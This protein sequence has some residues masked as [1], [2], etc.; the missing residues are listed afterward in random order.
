MKLLQQIGC[1]WV[2]QCDRVEGYLKPVKHFLGLTVDRTGHLNLAAVYLSQLNDGEVS[3]VLPHLMAMYPNSYVGVETGKTNEWYKADYKEP[4]SDLYFHS[5]YRN[6]R[7]DGAI[8]LVYRTAVEALQS[9]HLT[10]EQLVHCLQTW[11]FI[12]CSIQGQLEIWDELTDPEVFQRIWHETKITFNLVDDDSLEWISPEIIELIA[13]HFKVLPLFSTRVAMCYL[14][15]RYTLLEQLTKTPHEFSLLHTAVKQANITG[16]VC[17][18]SPVAAEWAVALADKSRMLRCVHVEDNRTRQH[19]LKVVLANCYDGR[20]SITSNL[21]YVDSI[22][23]WL[24]V[25][26]N[27]LE[28]PKGVYEK[29]VKLGGHLLHCIHHEKY[30]GYIVYRY[31][32]TSEVFV[33]EK[34]TLYDKC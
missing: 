33:V 27:Q 6:V 21:R 24:I 20:Q 10:N 28:L 25:S 23:D 15:W 9:L 26:S 17:T 14:Y 30:Y 29:Y 31:D 32:R 4:V 5:Y 8:Q 7:A 11:H 2:I 3:Q 13:P 12:H 18:I 19:V 34:Q 16:R 1:V 22:Y